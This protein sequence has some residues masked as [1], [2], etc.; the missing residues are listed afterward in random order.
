MR[1]VEIGVDFCAV[2]D[3]QPVGLGDI[4]VQISGH[5]DAGHAGVHHFHR[6]VDGATHRPFADAQPVQHIDLALGRAA[7]MAAHGRHDK[8]LAAGRFDQRHQHPG[9]AVNLGDAAAAEAERDA[10]A[11]DLR[12]QAQSRELAF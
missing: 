11:A 3:D 10:L 7:T 12:R 8:W 2:G 1:P 6:S 9:D 4:L 5:A